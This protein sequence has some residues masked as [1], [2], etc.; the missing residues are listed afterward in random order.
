M[1]RIGFST[2]HLAFFGFLLERKT[3]SVREY[4]VSRKIDSVSKD[5]MRIYNMVRKLEKADY[6]REERTE[7]K[8]RFLSATDKAKKEIKELSDLSKGLDVK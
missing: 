3:A 1:T 8:E 2:E 6:L 5:G 4:L 7:G